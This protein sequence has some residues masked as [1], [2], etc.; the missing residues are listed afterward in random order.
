MSNDSLTSLATLAA[1][2]SAVAAV[3]LVVAQSDACSRR[4]LSAETLATKRSAEYRYRW[5]HALEEAR[6]K[7]VY[8]RVGSVA[9]YSEDEEI[10]STEFLHAEADLDALIARL[11]DKRNPQTVEIGRIGR[12]IK[13]KDSKELY[14][15]LY[16]VSSKIYQLP[17]SAFA[18]KLADAVDR[19]VSSTTLCWVAD[20]SSMVGSHMIEDLMRASKTAVDVVQNPIWLVNLAA[21]LEARVLSSST[22]ERIVYGLGR[23]AGVNCSQSTL[24]ITY[25]AAIVSHMLPIVQ[26]VFADDRH[27]LVYTGAV[28]A[29]EY[30]RAGRQQY[31]K[32][33]VP[34][35]LSE[36]LAFTNP[37]VYTTPLCQS[38]RK[39]SNVMEPYGRALHALSITDAAVVETWMGAVDAF[40]MLKEEEK[41][42][43]YLPYVCKL[44]FLLSGGSLERGTDRFWSL[45]SLWQFVTGSRS[46]E[47]P[48]E[49]MDAAVS[50]LTDQTTPPSSTS[51]PIRRAIENAV[52]QHKL[53]LIENK[54][55]KD[56]VLPA[57]HW[58][59]K[60]AA[61]RGC[62]CC[63]PEEDEEDEEQSMMTGPKPDTLNGL[64]FMPPARKKSTNGGY[65][66]GKTTFAFDPSRFD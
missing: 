58:T 19:L 65:I 8:G 31:R 41:K 48:E 16:A 46:R 45:R 44:D 2:V 13:Q 63:L 4:I 66:D 26:K 28:R 50:W 56:T 35:S 21:I 29:V 22:V 25:G 39:S 37:V 47:V 54:T 43:G 23:L 14:V 49:V 64:S 59:L 6:L 18:N 32:G 36:A 7:T 24:V 40:F 34:A 57:E 61:K 30:A 10:L 3:G 9:A 60:A 53:I 38:L 12:D 33:S 15:W 52:F 62:A 11:L 42:N 1:G 27:A 17:L 51:A 55:L 5:N 20:A